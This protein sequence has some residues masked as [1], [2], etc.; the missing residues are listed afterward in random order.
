[1]SW[2]RCIDFVLEREGGY[3]DHASD[4]GGR[5]NFGI[6]QRAHRDI[7][8]ES[9]TRSQAADIYW[10]DYWLPCRCDKLGYPASLAVFDYAVNSGT[11][12]ATKALQRSVGATPDG[13]I[14][15]KTLR[16][17]GRSAPKSIAKHVTDQ[18]LANFIRIVRR[19]P[20]SLVFLKGWMRRLIHLTE[21]FQ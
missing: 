8:I 20:A 17:L 13:K 16:A 7:D 1:M 12:V 6:S 18:R 3:V 2:Q 5:T 10:K 9:L 21:A 4:P 14:G 15:P 11:K 19:R